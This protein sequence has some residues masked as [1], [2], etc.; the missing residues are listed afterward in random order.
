MLLL[1]S[2]PA[3][4]QTPAESFVEQGTAKAIAILGDKT[5]GEGQRNEKIAQLMTSLLDLKRMALFTLGPAVKSASPADLDTFV[6]AYR[7]FALA[8]YEAALG[9]YSGQTLT[10][11]GSTERAPGDYIVNATVTDP[12][13]KADAPAQVSF[14]VLDEGQG[15]LALV[16]ASVGGVWFTLAQRDDFTGFLGQNGGGV[17]KLAAHLKEMVAQAHSGAHAAGK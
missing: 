5:L 14:R 10:V 16:D 12:S 1:I 17:A 13:D 6:S 9:G 15:Q 3:W 2:T 11:S 8:N 4:P 7:D